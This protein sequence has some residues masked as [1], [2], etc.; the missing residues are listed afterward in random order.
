[1]FDRG[2][3]SSPAETLLIEVNKQTED[4]IPEMLEG[5]FKAGGGLAVS[6]C[7]YVVMSS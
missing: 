5:V 7:D 1:M 4:R 6:S 3:G 2:F